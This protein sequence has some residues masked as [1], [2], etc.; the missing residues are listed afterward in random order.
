MLG[1]TVMLDIILLEATASRRFR[2]L[3]LSDER[4]FIS[5]WVDNLFVV[6]GSS[7]DAIA[8]LEIVERIAGEKW[9][10]SF[11]HSSMSYVNASGL[12]DPNISARWLY[13]P[14]FKA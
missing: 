1:E 10:L 6:A 8:N 11:K 14:A 3:Q 4:L 5:S 9:S 7:Q 12:S 13:T 2:P